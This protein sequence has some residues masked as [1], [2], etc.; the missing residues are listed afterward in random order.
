M[1]MWL[2]SDFE[3]GQFMCQ[4]CLGRSTASACACYPSM[5]GLSDIIS[6]HMPSESNHFLSENDPL[7]A[8]FLSFPSLSHPS[9]NEEDHELKSE[10][11][12]V[13]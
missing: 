5:Q 8:D 1:S 9:S 3:R 10:A 6:L 11:C 2:I 12:H 7:C 4:H 13:R